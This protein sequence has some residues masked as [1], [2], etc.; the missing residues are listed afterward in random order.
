MSSISI[1]LTRTWPQ[2]EI[3]RVN[4]I[5]LEGRPQNHQTQRRTK[6]R[7]TTFAISETPAEHSATG[8]I[9]VPHIINCTSRHEAPR[10]RGASH[11]NPTVLFANIVEHRKRTCWM[12]HVAFNATT[13]ADKESHVATVDA[14]AGRCNLLNLRNDDA[15]DIWIMLLLRSA[16]FDRKVWHCNA[17]SDISASGS[18]GCC[19][20][21]DAC[22][23][24]PVATTSNTLFVFWLLCRV[25]GKFNVSQMW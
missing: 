13:T 19:G 3:H 4:L 18:F 20:G 24:F 5:L 17:V 6:S 14:Y 23:F 16:W 7:N 22:G 10:F 2:C 21:D 12:P 8:W 9:S 11:V 15:D 25:W 1:I